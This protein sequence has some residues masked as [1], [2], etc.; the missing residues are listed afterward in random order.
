MTTFCKVQSSSLRRNDTAHR[1]LVLASA[2]PRRSELLNQI[3]LQGFETRPSR[4]DET[5]HREEKPR[6]FAERMAREKALGSRIQENEIILA[7]D[8]VV[9][10]GRRIL[11]K[12]AG[13]DDA[14]KFLNLLSGRRHVVFTGVS[15]RAEA[16]TWVRSVATSV[17][18]KRLSQDEIGEYLAS[19][20]WRG[21]AGGYAIQ[22]LAGAFVLQLRGSYTNVVG[23]PLLETRNLLKAAG[24]RVHTK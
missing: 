14:R 1:R 17:Q 3:G 11:G 7:A 4:I 9:S 10:L 15:V 18:M 19:E 24:L 6:E 20:E 21:K 23:L 5:P 12:P 2:S 22:G 13:P 8:T 16:K